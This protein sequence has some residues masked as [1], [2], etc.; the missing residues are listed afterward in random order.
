MPLAIAK[1]INE[2]SQKVNRVQAGLD[3][4]FNAL[5]QKSIDGINENGAGIL[6]LADVADENSNGILDLAD[7][8]AELEKRVTA[9]EESKEV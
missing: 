7:Y 2:V 8:I 5:H 1:A 3:A 6:D 9:L 4:F